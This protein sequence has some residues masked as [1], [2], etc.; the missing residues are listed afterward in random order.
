MKNIVS[1]TELSSFVVSQK[2]E[3][4]LVGFVPTMGALHEGHL[5]LVE[6]A[7]QEC[8]VVIVSIFVNPT[9]FNDVSDFE[10]YPRTIGEDVALLQ[11]ELVD[12]V[13]LPTVEEVYPEN[14]KSKDYNFSPID[15]VMEGAHRPGHFAGVAMVVSRF[16][17]I[18]QPDKAYFG[19]KD[20]QQ[21]A[22]IK[23]MVEQ[24]PYTID[25]VS[26]PISREKSGLARS[27]RN[28]RLSEATQ[29]RMGCIYNV[30]VQAKDKL[31]NFTPAELES[32]AKVELEKEDGVEV[33]YVTV[34]D[35]KTLQSKSDWSEMKS[36]GIFV[37][38]FID[39]V[40]LI[41]NVILF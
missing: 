13:F 14:Y 3:N 17:D 39:K 7:K 11:S 8:D 6:K 15:E 40:R 10:L 4:K 26:C 38:L 5:S 31:N 12:V 29:H 34:A 27:S 24:H 23:S 16:F 30:L 35:G 32:W 36:A 1:T 28:K 2:S 41:D 37:A 19:S 9:Q 25:I 33:E 22:I 20:F 21:L 18:V